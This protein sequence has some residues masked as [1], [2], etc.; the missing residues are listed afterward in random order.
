MTLLKQLWRLVS[1]TRRA[2]GWRA[3]GTLARQAPQ[4]VALFSRLL[5]D[6]RVPVVAKVTLV[7]ALVYAVSPLDLIPDW[8][9]I[10]G[11]LDDIG[12]ALWAINFFL[13]QAPLE[14]LAEHRHAVG[15]PTNTVRVER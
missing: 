5:R 6:A 11:E 2:G 4:Q 8:L 10:M 7:G 13:G 1:I 9:P 14:A 3:L 15:L 12:V